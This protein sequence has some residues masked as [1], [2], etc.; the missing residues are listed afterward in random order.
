M[1]RGSEGLTRKTTESFLYL[2]PLKSEWEQPGEAGLFSSC[3]VPPD[4]GPPTLENPLSGAFR[5]RS[6]GL[7]WHGPA[8][9]SP[10]SPGLCRDQKSA[11]TA[12]RRWFHSAGVNARAKYPVRAA[13]MPQQRW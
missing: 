8:P 4:G 9:H 1:P 12:A 10:P 2:L 5:G 13:E 7:L 6:L 11:R 3:V